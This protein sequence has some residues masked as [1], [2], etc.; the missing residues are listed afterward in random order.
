MLR[1]K[2]GRIL[3]TLLVIT[4]LAGTINNNS[5]TKEERK[6]ALGLMKDT[7]KDVLKT[8]KGL[9][10]TQLDYRPAA[11]KWTVRECVYH[12]A[13]TEKGLW[14]M[15]EGM[16]KAPA[17]P[18]KRA[19]IKVSDE[20][21]VNMVKDR[22]RK[23]QAPENFQPKNITYKSLEEALSDF[24]LNR[25]AHI[26]YMKTSTEDLRNHVVQMPFGSID[27]YQLYL[28]IAAHSNRH[29]QQIKEV[30]ESKGFPAQ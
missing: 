13:A 18:E 4:G 26:R 14:S 9:S 10:E 24:K 20:E 16:M 2:T 29:T 21:F 1:R 27:C 22:S 5:L 28:M 7:Y 11:D 3:L 8:I 6:F 19:E 12:I 17:N 30:M 25:M 23:A 15:L